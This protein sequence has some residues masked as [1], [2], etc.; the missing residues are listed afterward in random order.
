VTRRKKADAL[1]QGIGTYTVGCFRGEGTASYWQ[2]LS[3][4]AGQFLFTGTKN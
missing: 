3:G 1:V 4:P 2:Q